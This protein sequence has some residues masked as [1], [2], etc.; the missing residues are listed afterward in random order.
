[1]ADEM[2]DFAEAFGLGVPESE[3]PTDDI[4]EDTSE[5]ETEDIDTEETED[6]DEEQS[7]EEEPESEEQPDSV[8]NSQKSRSDAQMNY[9]FAQL[10]SQNRELTKVLQSVG[11]I[12]GLDKNA[13][14][15]DL[16]NGV[17]QAVLQQQ[18]KDQ[19]IPI[20]TLEKISQLENL[21]EENNRI[22]LEKDTTQAFNELIEEFDLSPSQVQDF[23][24]HLIDSNLNP[25]EGK[26]VDLKAEYLKLHW[27]DMLQ[28][29]KDSAVE[30][31]N[32]R[33]EKVKN[34]AGGGVPDKKGG[35]SKDGDY[36]ISTVADLESFLSKQSL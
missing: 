21:V 18:A 36:E 2:R 9:K 29:A 22:K 31:E 33:R 3:D 10:R 16:I 13:S 15:V 25:L 17:K 6:V 4:D 23:T 30:S 35:I 20:E 8:D 27:Q 24:T 14:G 28:A 11:S 26:D 32:K 5:E 34:H 7:D 19:G 1:M 12:L